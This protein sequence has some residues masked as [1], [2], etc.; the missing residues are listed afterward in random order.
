MLPK[1]EN[2]LMC[3][4]GPGT[5][6][7]NF[8]R[9]YWI[10]AL[11]PADL[12]E[13]DGRPRRLRLL[14]ED[15]IG[16]RDSSGRAGIMRHNC[17]HRGASLFFGR[18]EDN[19][20]RCVYHGWKFDVDGRCVDMPNEPPES[21]FKDK[22]R[23]LA[24][25]CQERNGI[26]WTYMGPRDTPPPLP[27]LMPNLNPDCRV[28]T[29]LEE[30]N[31]MQALEGDI[32]TSHFGFLHAGHVQI[33]QLLFGSC[34]YYA[35]KQRWARFE[36]REHELGTSYA[37]IRPAEEGTE[38]W[39]MGHYMLP[40]YTINAPGVLGI[41]NSCIAWVPL[42]DDNTM[43][44]NIGQQ[45]LDPELSGIGGLKVG[46][47]RQ[48]PQGRFDPYAPR[49]RGQPFVRQFE[50]QT[51]DWL[52]M[53]RPIANIDNDYLMDIDL[54]RTGGTYTGLPNPAQDP[55][56]QETMGPIYDRSQEHLGTAD[57]MIIRTRQK[58][59]KAARG[60]DDG[61]AAP[62]V[63]DPRLFLMR[64]GGAILPKGSNGLDD[65]S[66]LHFGRTDLA[67]YADETAAAG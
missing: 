9:Q 54:Q 29:R 10:P 64:G 19:G 11:M 51:S 3:R 37:A 45:V 27:E 24:Y 65:L 48:D 8:I 41:K 67:T 1:E 13:A 38:Y 23:A 44:W 18:N 36:S 31:Y 15:L 60:V 49:Q 57:M 14:G 34:D 4:V 25:P 52:G 28:W 21:N 16:F 47:I 59:L 30:C 53:Y 12:D 62:G 55:M 17:P 43:V 32:D 63:D 50:A 61:A 40:F 2:E 7:G 33:D 46:W 26:I 20:L 6:M 56:A 5:L 35:L 66:D 42:D 22:V 39:R 58:L